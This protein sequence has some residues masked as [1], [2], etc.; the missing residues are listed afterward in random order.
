M[1]GLIFT[2]FLKMVEKRYSP[3][4]ADLI[5]EESDLVSGGAYTSLGNYD[6]RE[7]IELVQHL[8]KKT[9]VPIPDLMQAFGKYLFAQF[10]EKFPQFFLEVEDSFQFLSRVEDYIH[11][12]VKKL[13]PEAQ[14]PSFDYERPNPFSLKMTYR[15]KHP[16]ADL[17]HGLIEGC[18]EHYQ[19]QI[20]IARED[21]TSDGTSASFTLIKS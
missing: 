6:Y 14:L 18:V 9:N 8:S 16:F 1:K 4:M 12:E 3:E 13:Y 10:I 17:A 11:I 5:L 20:S 21:L 19:E 2:E 15:S 7:M